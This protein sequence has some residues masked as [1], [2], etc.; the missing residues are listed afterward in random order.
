MGRSTPSCFK[1]ITCA[2]D[3]DDLESSSKGKGSGDK[4]G[5]SFRKR[6]ARNQVIS[7]TVIL[8]AP[9]VNNESPQQAQANSS[10]P[11]KTPPMQCTDETPQLSMPV[12]SKLSEIMAATK[13]DDKFDVDPDESVI[14]VIQ[15]GIRGF[16]AQKELLKQKNI[17]K[18]QAAVRGHL[19][20]RNAVGT[21]RCVLAIVRMQALVRARRSCISVEGSSVE[22]KVVEKHGKYNQHSNLLHQKRNPGTQQQTYVSIAK[23]LSNSFA[24]QLLESTPRTK[25]INI[26]CDPSRSDSAWKWLERWMAVSPSGVEQSP[27][28]ELITGIEE[29]DNV[30]HPENQVEIVVPAA[31]NYCE[32]TDLKSSTV[33]AKVVSS[34]SEENLVTSHMEQPQ[35]EKIGISSSLEN[36]EFFPIKA[37]ESESISQA[38]LNFLSDKPGL[39]TEELNRSMKRAAPEQPET[40]GRKFACVSRKASNPA[41]IAAH[42]KFEE[43]TSTTNSGKSI[44]SSNQDLGAESCP[45]TV[46]SA[47]DNAVINRENELA[48]TS[49]P[50]NSKVQVGGSECGTELSITS[51]L[52]SPDRSEVGA[53]EFELEPKGTKNLEIEAEVEPTVSVQ[54]E[55]IDDCESVIAVNSTQIV[56]GIAPDV[57]VEAGPE[58]VH[59]EYKSSPGASPRSHITVLESQ[60]TPSSQIST[61]SKKPRGDKNKSNQKRKSLSASKRSPINPNQDSS[62]NSFERLP[63]DHKTGKRRNSFGSPRPDS[64]DQE[65]RD[66]SSS[67][68]LPSYMQ[69]TESAKAK[70]LA[71]GSSPRS[72]PDVQDKEMYIKKRH[73]LPGAN[74]RQGSPRIQ[75]STSQAQQSTKGNAAHPPERKWQR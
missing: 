29:H 19:V 21:L 54:L 44:S 12:S 49:V 68:S 70:A 48:G 43:L 16:L 33:E 34:E 1:I 24:R 5:W 4:R 40:E 74:G 55:K 64:V 22:D 72:S 8:E 41:F 53:V 52:D 30:K 11:E 37:M 15:V 14:I 60:G 73:S 39:E 23:L 28:L 56:E 13:E 31:E 27:K 46:S 2:G 20:R 32:P 9:S 25:A 6:S 26:K 69:A 7:N 10:V 35:H 62:A 3:A 67:N 57:Q 65:P 38:E 18:L 75:R 61:K 51:T 63:K 50:H 42:S 59:Q 45:D 36:S 58:A 66:S 17:V 71:S 47:T